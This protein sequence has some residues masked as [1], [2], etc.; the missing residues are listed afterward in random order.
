ML[1]NQGVELGNGTAAPD[2]SEL[3]DPQGKWDPNLNMPPSLASGFLIL[4]SCSQAIC[5]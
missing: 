2:G 3:A 1:S 4:A 5:K